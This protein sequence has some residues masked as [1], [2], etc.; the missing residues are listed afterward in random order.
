MRTNTPTLGEAPAPAPPR[1]ASRRRTALR[2]ACVL[3]PVLVST[4]IVVAASVLLPDWAGVC[5][6]YGGLTVAILLGTGRAEHVAVR[7]LFSARKMTRSEKV[8]LSA[9]VG[10]LCHLQ[11]GPPL[12]DLYVSR[13]P[14]GPHAVARGG[15]SVVMSAELA[16]AIQTGRIAEAEAMAVL[17]HASGT[18]R[19]GLVRLDPLIA[20]WTL[21]WRVLATTVRPLR[22]LIGF[23]WKIRPLV[24]GAA[25]W[26]SPTDPSA[27]DVVDG[28]AI[29]AVLAVSLVLT[30]AWPQM[31][32]GWDQ[33]LE[34]EGDQALIERG[35]GQPL[36]T[37]LRR[38]QQT[39]SVIER[40]QTL[41]PPVRPRPA[42]HI[43]GS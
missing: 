29:A 27:A 26:Q 22:G 42:L 28:V 34:R 36:A 33:A 12:V 32:R 11:L 37:F 9:V 25:I 20:L 40:T 2:L 30:Y 31:T 43:V 3:P 7:V 4:F 38:L 14:G 23:A 35:L 21:P 24:I 5:V 1:R 8:G 10:Q 6:F 17:A 41:D 18:A 16:I 13:R 15:R 39:P 19:S